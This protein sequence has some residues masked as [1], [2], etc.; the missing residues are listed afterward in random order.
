MESKIKIDKIQ[1][2]DQGN[3]AMWLCKILA[4]RRRKKFVNKRTYEFSPMSGGVIIS[5]NSKCVIFCLTF[6]DLSNKTLLTK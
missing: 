1:E 5:F 2:G 4:Y 6:I 3:N